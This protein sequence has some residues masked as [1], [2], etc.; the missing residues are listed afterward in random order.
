[1]TFFL[2]FSYYFRLLLLFSIEKI[3]RHRFRAHILPLMRFETAK[4]LCTLRAG[5]DY[6]MQLKEKNK[7]LNEQNLKYFCLLP[8]L[9]HT[10]HNESIN[11][12]SW[13][14][15]KTKAYENVHCS[16]STIKTETKTSFSRNLPST[17]LI[18]EL[19]LVAAQ[20]DK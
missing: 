10:C 18:V 3:M 13:H 7:R 19:F 12:L 4:I 14:Y 2:F 9:L 15:E 5:R 20:Q 11:C 1:M 17:I 8:L 6:I 16:L